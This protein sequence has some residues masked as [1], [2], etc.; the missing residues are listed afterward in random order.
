M[1]SSVWPQARPPRRQQMPLGSSSRVLLHLPLDA[2]APRD[3]VSRSSAQRWLPH[4]TQH[5]ATGPWVGQALSAATAPHATQGGLL[6]QVLGGSHR[7]PEGSAFLELLR[8]GSCQQQNALEQRPQVEP[9]CGWSRTQPGVGRQGGAAPGFHSCI[10]QHPL[11]SETPFN[12]FPMSL[13][14]VTKQD[15]P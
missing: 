11:P 8:R 13:L 14:Q 9:G 15:W 10:P 4:L 2:A 3:L 5:T 6:F 1:G 12:F 7:R